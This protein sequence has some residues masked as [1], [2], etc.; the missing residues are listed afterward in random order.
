MLD[1]RDKFTVQTYELLTRTIN[2]L[3]I[4]FEKKGIYHNDKV[5]ST[6]TNLEAKIVRIDGKLLIFLSYYLPKYL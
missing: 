3:E 1:Y 2:D 5:G 6:L 4:A